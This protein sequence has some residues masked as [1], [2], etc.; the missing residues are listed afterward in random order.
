[1]PRFIIKITD[2]KDN[3]DYYMM[4]STVVDAPVTYGLSLDEFKE[5]FKEWANKHPQPEDL[6]AAFE[7]SLGTNLDAAFDKLKKPGSL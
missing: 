1:M 3:K 7:K 2:E 4:W 6:K 5:Y